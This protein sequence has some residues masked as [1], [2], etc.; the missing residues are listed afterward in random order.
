MMR[1]KSAVT[2]MT[3]FLSPCRISDTFSPFEKQ[4]EAMKQ[5]VSLLYSMMDK[6]PDCLDI[7]VSC[8]EIT[9]V[10]RTESPSSFVKII[11]F[12]PLLCRR[13]NSINNEGAD[14]EWNF[15]LDP[16]IVI[17]TGTSEPFSVTQGTRFPEIKIWQGQ[18]PERIQRIITAR[19]NSLPPLLV[20]YAFYSKLPEELQKQFSHMYY[21]CHICCCGGELP[22]IIK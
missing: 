4:T 6:E 1:N 14:R 8:H 21:I 3:V 2:M 20:T 9:L 11:S 10:F 18:I 17:D 19:N 16:F 5:V 12:I 22:D 15:R 13:I 7:Q